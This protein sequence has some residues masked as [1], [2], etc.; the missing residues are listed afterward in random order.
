MF[1]AM[2]G[3]GAFFCIC[4]AFALAIYLLQGDIEQ[5]RQCIGLLYLGVPVTTIGFYGIKRGW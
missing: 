2:A 4:D 5:V 3:V 1:E